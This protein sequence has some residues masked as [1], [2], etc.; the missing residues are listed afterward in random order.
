VPISDEVEAFV[1]GI[2]LELDPVLEGAEVVADMQS[3][4]GAHAGE[5]AVCGGRQVFASVELVDSLQF[6]VCERKRKNGGED[7]EH[8]TK[9]AQ[10]KRGERGC[11]WELWKDTWLP[12]SLHSAAGAPDCGPEEKSGRSGRDD[13]I[14]GEKEKSG[15]VAALDR[16]S[17]PF[18]K[19][20]KGG[21]PSSFWDRDFWSDGRRPQK[22]RM[23][24]SRKSQDRH[25]ENCT[26]RHPREQL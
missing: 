8:L 21:A 17:P 6:T 26:V 22:A 20:A 5:D 1:V 13:G 14:G 7:E 9:R 12:R 3:S 16:K 2:G 18:A 25:P 24:H 19:S 23:G 10:R 4:G 15:K 11:P